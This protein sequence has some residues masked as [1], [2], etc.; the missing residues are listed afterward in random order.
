MSD[1]VGRGILVAAVD[2]GDVG[3]LQRPSRSHNRGV[4]DRLDTVISAVDPDEDLRSLGVN[5]ACRCD[6]VLPLQGGN[7]I[8]CRH[9]EGCQ[10]GIGKLN[11]YVFGTFTED[12]DLLDA[13][14]VQEVLADHLR[15]P[16]QIAH[17][18]APGL[19]GI[20][21][22]AYV[23]IFI[24]DE[25]A[26]HAGRQVASFIAELL[27]GLVELLLND[28]WRRAVLQCNRHIRISWPR[29]RLDAVVPSQLL[30]P[31]LQR[32][33]NEVLHLTRRRA[34]PYRRHRQKS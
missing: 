34:R 10:F 29:G 8:L 17:R 7:N 6:G 25:G 23:R 14:H 4:G 26:E 16:D 12:V 15:L 30:K 27:A 9:A 33:G 18:H 31:L 22:E 19:E 24:V 1:D 5:R 2:F 13:G 20:K 28:R 32:F 3:E 21:C 11:E